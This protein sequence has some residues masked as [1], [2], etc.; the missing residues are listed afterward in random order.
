MLEKEEFRAYY[1]KAKDGIARRYIDGTIHPS[2]AQRFLRIYFPLLK[3]EENEKIEFEAKVKANL[4]ASEASNL[5]TLLQ[6]LQAGD[7]TQ[8]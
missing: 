2:I 5:I 3:A 8:K 1:E 7:I 6:K 4:T